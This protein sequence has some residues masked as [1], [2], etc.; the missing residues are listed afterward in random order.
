MT[1]K[2]IGVYAIIFSMIISSALSM[3]VNMEGAELGALFNLVLPPLTGLVALFLYFFINWLSKDR[4]VG[5]ITIILCCLY[6][7]YMGIVFHFQEGYLPF[8]FD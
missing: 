8:P 4:I 2:T 1:L 7:I 6:L 5:I 3:T